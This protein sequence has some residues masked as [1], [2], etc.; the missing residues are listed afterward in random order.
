MNYKFE[1]VVDGLYRYIDHEIMTGMNDL[2]EIVARIAIGR[3]AENQETIKKSLM[4]NGV[5]RS[6]GIMDTDGCVDVENLAKDLKRE[7][8]R[9]G[10]VSV[11][12]PMIGKL[13]FNAQDIDTIKQYITGER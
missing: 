5:I 11:S 3:V 8:E 6:F 9:K 12:I 1:S 10:K 2:Q 7:I 13:T 4:N